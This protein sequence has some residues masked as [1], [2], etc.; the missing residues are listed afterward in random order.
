MRRLSLT[1]R[2]SL[3]FMLAVIAVLA[4]AGFAFNHLSQRHFE[5]LD[6]HTLEDKLGASERILSSLD[7]PENFDRIRPELLALLGGHRDLSALVVNEGGRVLFSDSPEVIPGI[8]PFG[9]TLVD[10]PK[11]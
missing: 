2:L 8:L 9:R 10:H 7:R 11:G 6:R 4:A 1:A 5:L 3:M